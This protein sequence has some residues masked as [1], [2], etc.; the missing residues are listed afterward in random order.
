VNDQRL[1][2]AMRQ[3][4]GAAER[5]HGAT[6]PNPPVGCAVLDARGELVGIGGTQRPPGWHAEVVALR[7]AGERARGGTAVVT[8]EPCA[9]HGRTPPCTDALLAAGVAQVHYAVPDPNPRAAGGAARL[10]AHGV[11]V[12]S[13]LLRTD[14]EKGALRAWLHFQKARRPFVTWKFGSTLDGRVAAGDGTS[15]WITSPESRSDVH[16]LRAGVDAIVVGTGTA[17]ADDPA[18]TVRGGPAPEQRRP[19]R[20]VVGTRDLPPDARLHDGSAETLHLRTH[21]PDAVLT[22]LAARDAV[23]VLLEG[24]PT[25]AGAFLKA[26]R[27][28]RVLCYLAPALLGAGPAALNDA[29]I[30]T[31]ADALRLHVEDVTMLGP[32]LRISAVR[33]AVPGES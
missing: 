24:G 26:G 28:D 20:V 17:L 8:L 32:D 12:H 16:V 27:I 25:L 9:H 19:I 7:Q 29:G 11:T 2:W 21:D 4:I 1:E 33:E 18:L 22:E 14:V 10:A 30:G 23:D 6:S 13:G 5:V 3:A 31:I 15:R